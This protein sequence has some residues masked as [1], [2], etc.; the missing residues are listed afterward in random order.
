MAGYQYDA[1]EAAS[2]KT[3]S[4]V[5]EADSPKL[6]RAKLRDQGLIGLD[7]QVL[8]G[9]AQA[10]G[11]ALGRGLPI[12]QLALFTRQFAVLL[13]AGLT[14]EQA[15]NALIEQ[16]EHLA[17]RRILAAIRG[18]IL[19]GQTLARALDAHRGAFPDLYRT[20]IDAGEQTGK[21]GQVLLRLADYLEARHALRQKIGL[22]L[23]YP[24]IISAV[25]LLVVFGLLT[26]VVPQVIAV[27]QDSKQTLPLLTRA[28]IALSDGLKSYGLYGF[29]VLAVAG[30]AARKILQLPLW[31]NRLDTSLLRLP[32][33]GKLVR[34]MNTA[35]FASTL[36]IL[37][38]SGV[39]LLRALSAGAGVISNQPMRLAV[40]DA[41]RKVREGGSLSRAIAQSKVFPPLFV[42]LIASGEA[43]GKL[44][45]MLDRAATQQTQELETRAA[46]MTGLF[47]PLLIL[48]MGVIVL[49][50][51]LAILLPIFE[52]NQLVH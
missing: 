43:S 22:A 5:I 31:R 32:L 45:H 12:V 20:L 9:E 46:V 47:E 34:G 35:R 33:F 26:Y 36:A 27:F 6:A 49:L 14:I 15:L 13:E 3:R 19:A 18:D 10:A 25:A 21:L 28:L 30:Y 42:H 51:V 16:T 2:G 8:G 11:F 50:I 1:V 24:A 17:L 39:P 52:M 7:V 29:G 48:V 41:A 40:E 44:E 23:I 38:G 37:V 4:G